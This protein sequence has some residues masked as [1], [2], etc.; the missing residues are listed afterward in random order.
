MI[1]LI[2]I[3]VNK[4]ISIVQA[5]MPL[6]VSSQSSFEAWLLK[7]GKPVFSKYNSHRA[8][9]EIFKKYKLL[10]YGRPQDVPGIRYDSGS[11]QYSAHGFSYDEFTVTNTYSLMIRYIPLIRE[12]GKIFIWGRIRKYHG[13]DYPKERNSI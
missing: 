2:V 5:D 10:T 9:Y 3:C 12:N 11:K 1:S 7:I 6:P 13:N 4:D 8:N